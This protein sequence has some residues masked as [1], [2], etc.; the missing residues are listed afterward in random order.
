MD[1][2]CTLG[3][4]IN[5]HRSIN[6]EEMSDTIEKLSKQLGREGFLKKLKELKL[7][8]TVADNI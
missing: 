7:L 5:L 2:D 6:D 4:Q 8:P 1:I 3:L